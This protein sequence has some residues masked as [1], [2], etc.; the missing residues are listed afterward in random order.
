MTDPSG[1]TFRIV[2]GKDG[3]FYAGLVNPAGT[4]VWRDPDGAD[5][6]DAAA[7]LAERTRQEIARATV[8][9]DSNE[10]GSSSSPSPPAGSSGAAD[11]GV[12]LRNRAC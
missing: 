4:E 10:E 2:R 12:E 5:T 1:W 7:R 3:R 9:G 11:G 6:A 8:S